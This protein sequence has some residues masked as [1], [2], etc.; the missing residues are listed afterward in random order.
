MA[1]SSPRLGITDLSTFAL[2]R[3]CIPVSSPPADLD[4]VLQRLHGLKLDWMHLGTMGR[5]KN[6]GQCGHARPLV[7]CRSHR[8]SG[9]PQD[10]HGE[11]I[12]PHIRGTGNLGWGEW[13]QGRMSC[14]SISISIPISTPMRWKLVNLT[15]QRKRHHP[16]TTRS[17]TTA[18]ATATAT[19]TCHPF[20]LLFF[21]STV[22][23]ARA[24]LSSHRPHPAPRIPEAGA[25]ANK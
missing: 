6:G 3:R 23:I 2:Q 13:K 25:W 17:R 7:V 16:K 8:V 15:M 22:T 12:Y 1:R 14:I 19:A 5:T 21:P 9:V 18:T 10:G 11:P 4:P 20:S 24:S